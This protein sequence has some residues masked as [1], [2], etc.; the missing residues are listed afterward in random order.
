[1]SSNPT[2]SQLSVQHP[3]EIPVLAKKAGVGERT[4]YFMLRG[5][6]VKRSEAEKVLAGLSSLLNN[7]W[8]FTLDMVDVVLEEEQ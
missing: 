6:P 4:V 7:G 8:D 1:M 3:F 5:L 2:F